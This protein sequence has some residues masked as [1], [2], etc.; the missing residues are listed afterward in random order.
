[1]LRTPILVPPSRTLEVPVVCHGG[2]IGGTNLSGDVVK[3]AVGVIV[4]TAFIQYLHL[5]G[6]VGLCCRAWKSV[7]VTGVGG[8]EPRIPEEIDDLL[9]NS[10]WKRVKSL[11]MGQEWVALRR[12]L[13]ASAISLG[14]K[15]VYLKMIRNDIYE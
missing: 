11:G 15:L 10:K 7:R 5:F 3:A 1:M 6:S 8:G 12:G 14:R 4:V 13:R 9:H 2:F